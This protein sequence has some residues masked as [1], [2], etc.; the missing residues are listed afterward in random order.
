[1]SFNPGDADNEIVQPSEHIQS[2]DQDG[3]LSA[4]G[5]ASSGSL[6]SIPLYL[7]KEASTKLCEVYL[8]KV[9]PVSTDRI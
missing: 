6:T 1:M 3:G 5:I 9:D 8:R 4:L 7:N 2:R